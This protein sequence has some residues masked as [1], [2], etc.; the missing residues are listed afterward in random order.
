MKAVKFSAVLS[1]RTMQFEQDLSCE[2]G[3]RTELWRDRII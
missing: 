3:R 2:R 1:L